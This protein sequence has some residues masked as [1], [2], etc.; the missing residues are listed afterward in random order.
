MR[1]GRMGGGGGSEE[2]KK[3]RGWGVERDGMG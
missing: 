3:G 2:G 1:T